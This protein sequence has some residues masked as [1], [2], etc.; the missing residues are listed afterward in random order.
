MNNLPKLTTAQKIGIEA[1][2]YLSAKFTKTIKMIP[3]SQ[4]I[5]LGIDF[6]CEI[7]DNE[8]Q[9]ESVSI[10]NAKVLLNVKKMRTIFFQ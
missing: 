10:F 6:Y 4:S 8:I 2:N 1:A 9:L 7:L 5:D 3:I